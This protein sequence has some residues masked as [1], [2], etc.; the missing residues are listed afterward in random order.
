MQP[1]NLFG[2]LLYQWQGYNAG[3]ADFTNIA[4]AVSA[5]YITPPLV[6]QV[7]GYAYR[8]IVQAPSLVATSDVATVTVTADVIPPIISSVGSLDGRVISVAFSEPVRSAE[9]LDQFRWLI[10]GEDFDVNLTVSAIGISA[11]NRYA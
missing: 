5:T 8:V 10:N 7:G 11:D 1:T 2:Q 9:V 6:P 3:L 4:G